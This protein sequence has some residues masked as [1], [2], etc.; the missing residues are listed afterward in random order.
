MVKKS[1]NEKKSKSTDISNVPTQRMQ[2]LTRSKQKVVELDDDGFEKIP[3]DLMNEVYGDDNQLEQILEEP[4]LPLKG[5]FKGLVSEFQPM[6]AEKY[7]GTQN[8]K[9]WL[10]SEK[11]DGIRCIWNG[12]RLYSRNNNEFFPPT[13]FTENFPRNICLDGELFLARGMFSETTSVVKKKK[14]HDG[15]NVIKYVVFDAPFVNAKLTERLAYVESILSTV[16]S[17]YIVLHKQEILKDT[18]DLDQRMKDIVKLNGEG[19]MLRDPRSKYENRR[20]HSMLKVKEFHDAEA[21]VVGHV[22]GTGRICNLMGALEVK[23]FD[24][25]SFKIGTGF[26]D[27]ERANP[28][29]IGSIVTYRYFELSKDKVPRFPSYV[30]VHPGM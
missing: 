14:A 1:V 7:D 20:S 12:R 29:K 17:P 28:P 21:L 24:G 15:W 25:I 22:K 18:N 30:R 23:N 13:W 11:L 3:E 8:V 4:E 27:N 19:L 5:A 6:L 16:D 9:D 10:V 26:D 2:H